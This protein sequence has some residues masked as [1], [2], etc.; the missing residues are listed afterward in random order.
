MPTN[1]TCPTA[2]SARLQRSAIEALRAAD[3]L[4]A[5]PL[6]EFNADVHLAGPIAILA[7]ILDQSHYQEYL[8]VNRILA[9]R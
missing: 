5:Q 3:K 1:R 2:A 8:R 6:D 4:I 9:S 7:S